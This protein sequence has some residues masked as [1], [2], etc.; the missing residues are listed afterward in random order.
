MHRYLQPQTPQE[1]MEQM[2]KVPPKHSQPKPKRS[3]GR[4]RK[5]IGVSQVLIPLKSAK[6]G[7]RKMS[8]I[9]YNY[10]NDIVSVVQSVKSFRRAVDIL[11]MR[12]WNV[13]QSLTH[14]GVRH[15]FNNKT[16]EL[17]PHALLFRCKGIKAIVVR[18][19]LSCLED[20]NGSR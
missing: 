13:F 6:E 5:Q 10:A 15:W 19:M 12:N 4:P 7:T 1:R 18:M 3:V 9:E 20:I 8:W 16:F 11:K 2:L 14:T 17:K